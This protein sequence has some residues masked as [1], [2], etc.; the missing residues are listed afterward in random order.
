MR[1]A[2]ALPHQEQ[3]NGVIA[4]SASASARLRCVDCGSCRR[5]VLV[6]VGINL[7]VRRPLRWN[8]LGREDGVYWALG[9]TGA[10]VNALIRINKELAIGPLFEVNAVNWAD[11]DA[12]R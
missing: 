7:D 11:G 8:R 12:N 2:T 10:A 6:P 9:L 5:L 4:L 3:E 1:G